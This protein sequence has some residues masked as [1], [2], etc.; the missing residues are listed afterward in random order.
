MADEKETESREKRKPSF[1]WLSQTG[2]VGLGWLWTL[3]FTIKAKEKKI[4]VKK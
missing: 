1:L 4:T 3:G 2:A